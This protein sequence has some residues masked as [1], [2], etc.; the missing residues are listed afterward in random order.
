MTF[1]CYKCSGM[2][3]GKTCP[4]DPKH[5]L[6]VS[7]T[8]QREMLSKGEDVPAE[9]SRP[10]VVDHPEGVLQ[11]PLDGVMHASSSWL[12]VELMGSPCALRARVW[13]LRAP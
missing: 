2:A 5:H 3:T 7:G 12:N 10:E 8:R 11:G 13:A 4:H 6:S 9:F 1:Y